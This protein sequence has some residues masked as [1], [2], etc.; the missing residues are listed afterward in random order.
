M[1]GIFNGP[2]RVSASSPT[3]RT[4]TPPFGPASE[5]ARTSTGSTR[6]SRTKHKSSKKRRVIWRKRPTGFYASMA[7]GS[8]AS[9]SPA[10]ASPKS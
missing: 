4:S 7:R 9:S 2:S 1:K 5:G 6:P 3:A 10:I 8:S